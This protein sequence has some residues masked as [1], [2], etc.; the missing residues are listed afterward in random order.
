MDWVL[1]SGEF[2]VVEAVIARSHRN[3][4]YPSDHFPYTVALDWER[5]L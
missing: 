2:R 3:G 5:K 1:V 4:R